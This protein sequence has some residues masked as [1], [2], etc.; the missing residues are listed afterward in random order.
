M[1]CRFCGLLISRYH[2]SFQL[3]SGSKTA[4][5]FDMLLDFTPHARRTC[6]G[7]VDIMF[8]TCTD[9]PEMLLKI[10]VFERPWRCR[11]GG[12]L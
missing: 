9:T 11:D 5:S 8:R 4:L 12:G 10:R 7:T 2:R 3:R 1:V 6:T